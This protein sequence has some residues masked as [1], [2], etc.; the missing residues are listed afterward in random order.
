MKTF[1]LSI[2]MSDK[3]YVCNNIKDEDVIIKEFDHY[4]QA[5]NYIDNTFKKIK[6]GCNYNYY[7]KTKEYHERKR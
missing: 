4:D 6:N 3:S 2:V 1:K 5:H 7:V